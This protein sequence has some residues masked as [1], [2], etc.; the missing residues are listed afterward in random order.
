MSNAEKFYVSQKAIL[1]NDKGEILAIRRTES[2]P[3]WPLHWDLPGGVLDYGEDM[4]K[5][6]VR[7]I[8]EETGL[9]VTNLKVISAISSF[10]DQND[11]WATVC[12]VANPVTDKVKL[13]FE[14]DDFRWVAP[15]EFL[16]LRISPKIR[17]FVENYKAQKKL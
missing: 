3:S 6:I 5:S 17:K 10:S 11:F 1:V 13:S 9:S 2:A 7:E 8:I 12:Y 4:E 16:Q 15:D 14:H